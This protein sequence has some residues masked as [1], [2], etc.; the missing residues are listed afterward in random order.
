M[1]T[2]GEKLLLIAKWARGRD[3]SCDM[4]EVPESAPESST[5]TPSGEEN[6]EYTQIIVIRDEGCME[7]FSHTEVI[8]HQEI[9]IRTVANTGLGLTTPGVG[10]IEL[11]KLDHDTVAGLN[12]FLATIQVRILSSDFVGGGGKRP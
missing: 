2:K 1:K 12:L 10:M 5:G 3:R 6:L 11:S 9:A 8:V 4:Q 7:F